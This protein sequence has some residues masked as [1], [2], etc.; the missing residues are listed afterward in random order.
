MTRWLL[1]AG[2]VA[3]VGMIV[4]GSVADPF[5]LPFP[6]YEDLPEATRQAYE[7][8]AEAMRRLR[9]GGAGVVAFALMAMLARR[10]RR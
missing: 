5:S 10:L 7:A 8:R 1:W 3:G 4:V 2:L 9:W 6:D